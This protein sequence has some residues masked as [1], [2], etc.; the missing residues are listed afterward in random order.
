[1]LNP[2]TGLLSGVPSQAGFFT[3][4]LTA[5]DSAVIG[6]AAS[7]SNGTKG[8]NATSATAS[9]T[10]SLTVVPLVTVIP[11]L[12]GGALGMMALAMLALGAAALR[13]RL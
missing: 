8:A 12:S 10:Y 4:Q 6:N 7:G 9:Q 3:F 13:R 5:T 11:T 2:A 1:M